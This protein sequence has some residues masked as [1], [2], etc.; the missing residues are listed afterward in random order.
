MNLHQVRAYSLSVLC[1]VRVCGR[2]RAGM[3]G[4]HLR[5][6]RVLAPAPLLP[7]GLLRRNQDIVICQRVGEKSRIF[8]ISPP[9]QIP[10]KLVCALLELFIAR[11]KGN[12][13]FGM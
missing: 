8:E 9:D 13:L 6:D 7:G 4:L 5:R 10:K 11:A 1:Q 2:V 3:R 12:Y